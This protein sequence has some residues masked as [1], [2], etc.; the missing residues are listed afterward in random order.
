MQR[1]N[2]GICKKQYNANLQGAQDS[3]ILDCLQYAEVFPYDL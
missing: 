2:G 1:I 3:V